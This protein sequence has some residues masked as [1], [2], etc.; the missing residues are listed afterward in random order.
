VTPKVR[1]V[2]AIVQLAV[3]L[4]DGDGG[5]L[6]SVRVDPIH[7]TP[8]QFRAFGGKPL[9]AALADLEAELVADET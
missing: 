9:T 5:D 3:V 7:M 4:D 1:L 2:G 8:Q 6:T